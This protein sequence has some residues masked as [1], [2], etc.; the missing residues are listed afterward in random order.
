[1]NIKEIKE[2]LQL[3]AEH[4]LSEVEIEKDG[5]KIKLKKDRKSVV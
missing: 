2:M 3:M 5:L 4:H 1:M